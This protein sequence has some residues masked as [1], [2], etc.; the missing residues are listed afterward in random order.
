M[1]APGA[2]A[3]PVMRPLCQCTLSAERPNVG[4]GILTREI[5]I[6]APFGANVLI[7]ATPRE[8]STAM[9]ILNEF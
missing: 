3:T 2:R 6:D 8:K 9:F 1:D 5:L 7:H 4:K